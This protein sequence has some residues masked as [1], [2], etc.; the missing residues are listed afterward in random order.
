MLCGRG[1]LSG[2]LSLG[3]IDRLKEYTLCC[4]EYLLSKIH[5]LSIEQLLWEFDVI[6]NNILDA[7]I[8]LVQGTLKTIASIVSHDPMLLAGELILRLKTIKRKNSTR[9]QPRARHSHASF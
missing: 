6:C 5:G 3:D 2:S 1:T 7:D 8:L 4:F 9:H